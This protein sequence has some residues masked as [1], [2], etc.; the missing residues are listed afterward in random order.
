MAT[1]EL[2]NLP[3]ATAPAQF[4]GY[5]SYETD[6]RGRSDGPDFDQNP[7]RPTPPIFTVLNYMVTSNRIPLLVKETGTNVIAQ[8]AQ[9]IAGPRRT[10]KQASQTAGECIL[11][12]PLWPAREKNIVPRLAK[13]VLY[14][15]ESRS[16]TVEDSLLGCRT[17]F[18]V[19][20]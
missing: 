4:A 11:G 5:R 7:D 3:V 17:D 16:V 6:H 20:L 1:S 19:L 18:F 15:I 14:A 10:R 9:L 13:L 2:D 8:S 12:S